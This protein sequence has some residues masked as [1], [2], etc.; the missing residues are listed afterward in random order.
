MKIP[1]QDDEETIPP[2][3]IGQ[4]LIHKLCSNSTIEEQIQLSEIDQKPYCTNE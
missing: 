1:H 3:K 2:I 4:K